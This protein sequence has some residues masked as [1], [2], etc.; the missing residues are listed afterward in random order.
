MKR[1]SVL[2]SVSI[3]IATYNSSRTLLPC[4]E[5]VARQT[6]PKKIVEVILAD[7][8]SHDNTKLLGRKFGATVINV[9][10]KKQNA[11][12]NKGVGLARAKGDI[13]LFLDH[14]NIMPHAE[15][16]SAL[17]KPFC[18]NSEI[19]GVEPLRFHYD[20]NMTLLDRYFAL[21]G[22]SDPVV[23]Y[24]GKNSHASW[25][26]EGYHMN[27]KA[28]DRGEYYEVIF[29]HE[30]LPALGGNGAALRRDYLV[31]YAQS[32]PDHFVHT[33]VVYDIVKRGFVTY[34]F[35]K[36]TIIHLTNNKVVPFLKRRKY[37]IEQYQFEKE[38]IRRYAVYDTKRDTGKLIYYILISLTWV[39]PSMD[40]MR[41]YLSVRDPAWF[42]HP[43]FCFV[44]TCI[45]G[46]AVIER[47]I[48]HV[49][50]A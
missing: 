3:I 48:N 12:Y 43:V 7:G 27:G 34:A 11:E 29:S 4:L 45:Y 30:N 23:Y 15:W 31:L 33:D 25:A 9:D 42:L 28:F 18:Q 13:V 32:D 6:Y 2:P 24:L 36:D 44:Y 47:K 39:V 41:G 46:W 10:P 16:L 19:I 37:F 5:S 21:I 14:D 20:P 40:A 8:G 26:G 17:M 49:S 22:G 35:I 1:L 50:L 38:A